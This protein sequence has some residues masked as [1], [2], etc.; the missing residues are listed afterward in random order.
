MADKCNAEIA[1]CHVVSPEIVTADMPMVSAELT[2]Q[3][4]EGGKEMLKPIV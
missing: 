4:V 3:R 2:Q 1:L